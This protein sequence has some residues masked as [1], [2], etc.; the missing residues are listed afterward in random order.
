MA[1]LGIQIASDCIPLSHFLNPLSSKYSRLCLSDTT[2]KACDGLN[3]SV[4]FNQPAVMNESRERGEASTEA[5][6]PPK[7]AGAH[8]DPICEH[9]HVCQA[10]QSAEQPSSVWLLLWREGEEVGREGRGGGRHSS[11]CRALVQDNRRQPLL[12]STLSPITHQPLCQ[13]RPAANR[14]R[15]P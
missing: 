2:C 15:D 8:P 5:I 12:T 10:P 11:P 1:G 6:S 9:V 7:S 14:G 4:C 13:C 3:P